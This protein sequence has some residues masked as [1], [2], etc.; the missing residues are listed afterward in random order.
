[1]PLSLSSYGG[2]GG[3]TMAAVVNVAN[4]VFWLMGPM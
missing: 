1:V 2:G 3:N 4:V